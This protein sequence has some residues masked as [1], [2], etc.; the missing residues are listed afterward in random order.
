MCVKVVGGF[1]R[2]SFSNSVRVSVVVVELVVDVDA[3]GT[4]FVPPP[5]VDTVAVLAVDDDKDVAV[6][7]TSEE[8][9][10]QRRPCGLYGV[11]AR[12]AN[13]CVSLTPRSR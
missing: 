11:R 12:L 5:F 6:I 7:D 10:R 8:G 9:A 1:L 2:K 4:E 3:C 13:A